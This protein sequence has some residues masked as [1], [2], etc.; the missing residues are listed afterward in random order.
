MGLG[1]VGVT[2]NDLVRLYGGLAR[3]GT[4]LQLREL[5]DSAADTEPKRLM[6]EVAAWHVGNVLIGAP[7]PDNGLHNRIAFKTGTSY[8][9]RDAW[10]V[11]Y[12]GGMTIGVWVGRPDGAP[13]PGLV[14]RLSAAPILFDAFARSG[15]LP[16][17]L[18]KAPK[19]T[20]AAATAKLPLPLQRYR[21]A[22]ELTRLS[23]EAPLR[24]QFPLDG[25]RLELAPGQDGKPAPLS[26]K[27]SG[28]IGPVTVLINGAPVGEP[29]TGRQRLVDAPGPGFMRLTVMDAR[30]TADTVVVR[31]Q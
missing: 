26:L 3:G 11:G 18:A 25:S 20:L 8:G 29:G 15:R 17:P 24:I 5:M 22:G 6:D 14:G 28:G 9:Y 21:A 2:L 31:I 27:V 12:D 7:P 10:A 23:A 13:V 16:V 1:G 19:G 4:T 30:G